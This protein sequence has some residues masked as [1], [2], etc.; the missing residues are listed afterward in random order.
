M[1]SLRCVWL[2]I[3]IERS[4]YTSVCRSLSIY[5]RACV[6]A[7]GVSDTSAV[8]SSAYLARRAKFF[9]LASP[10]KY[11]HHTTS[12]LA[13]CLFVYLLLPTRVLSP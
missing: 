3:L 11:H 12:G 8:T 10:P 6:G 5:V 13:S 2:E 9:L 7:C 4:V 1:S